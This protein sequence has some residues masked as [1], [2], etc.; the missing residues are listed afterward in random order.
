MHFPS[1]NAVLAVITTAVVML[2]VMLYN[3]AQTTSVILQLGDVVKKVSL[4]NLIIKVSINKNAHL[5]RAFMF[6]LFWVTQTKVKRFST[7]YIFVSLLCIIYL[8]R[9][10]KI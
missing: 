5:I 6:D 1:R 4:C 9:I 7:V 3:S 8:G 10:T 2:L